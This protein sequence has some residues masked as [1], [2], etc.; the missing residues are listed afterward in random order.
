LSKAPTK[1]KSTVD[2][3]SSPAVTDPI[4]EEE[5]A[6]Q[7]QHQHQQQQQQQQFELWLDLRQTTISPQA[8]LLHLTNDLWD[9]YLAPENKCFLIDKVL[10]NAMDE[11]NTREVIDDIKD[12]YEEE[13]EVFFETDDGITSMVMTARD[14]VS[15][16]DG[17]SYGDNGQDY[18]FSSQGQGHKFQIY[19]DE[20]GV[21]NVYAN[22]MPALAAISSGEWIVLDSS[23]D[24]KDQRRE[25]IQSLVELCY[26]S[27]NTGVV[28]LGEKTGDDDEDEKRDESR[29]GGI[30]IDCSSS[31]E[32]FEAGALIKSLSGNQKGFKKTKSGILV[33]SVQDINNDGGTLSIVNQNES[34]KYAILI[35]LDAL[36]WKTASFV[37]GSDEIQ[38]MEQ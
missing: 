33:Q 34:M 24:D 7:T 3:S 37:I 26:G 21:I 9:E 6:S 17:D 14:S 4:S 8:A 32:I 27:L 36:L 19:D 13:I 31:A 11:T 22:P 28:S 1:L 18:D 30:V 25:A 23:L 38:S 2:P 16:A 35:P 29:M 5:P 20:T 15:N 12:E 10:V